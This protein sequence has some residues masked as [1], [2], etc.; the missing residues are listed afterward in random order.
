MNNILLDTDMLMWQALHI[1]QID[2]SWDEDTPV[3]ACDM[4]LARNHYWDCVGELVVAC[5]SHPDH[6]YHCFT[7]KSF[8]RRTIFPDYKGNRPSLKLVGHAAFKA[9]LLTQPT[10]LMFHEIE[11]DDTIS[12]MADRFRQEAQPYRVCSGDKDMRQVP[13]KHYWP[14]HKTE[15]ERMVTVTDEQA[16]RTFWA[17]TLAGDPGDNVPGCPKVGKVLSARWAADIDLDDPCQIWREVVNAYRR[18]LRQ[19]HRDDENPGELALL[20]ARLVR[21]LKD[22]DYDPDTGTVT[23]WQPPTTL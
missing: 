12:I 9:E 23:L 21:L 10:A 19:M 3:R 14:W 1:A 16:E 4:R 17:Q 22:G 8:F 6:V 15:A 13:G 5:D 18:H 7:D 20:T 11:A 2:E